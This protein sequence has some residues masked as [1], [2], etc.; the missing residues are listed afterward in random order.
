[1]AFVRKTFSGQTVNMVLNNFVSV[2]I[3]DNAVTIQWYPTWA[4]GTATADLFG[5]V[6]ITNSG[7]S[8]STST[9]LV[10]PQQLSF[11][12]DLLVSVPRR[13]KDLV[14]SFKSFS[15]DGANPYLTDVRLGFTMKSGF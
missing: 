11:T 2:N 9:A 4:N 15:N 14:I 7:V 5:F 3:P 10:F 8:P 13:S 12:I 6:Q 1:M